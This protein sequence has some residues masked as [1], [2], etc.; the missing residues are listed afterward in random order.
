MDLRV[1]EINFEGNVI[2][3]TTKQEGQFRKPSDNSKLISYL[4]NFKF[5]QIEEGPKETNNW[6]ENNYKNIRK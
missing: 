6:F 1:K 2:F 3:D 5:T 4:P